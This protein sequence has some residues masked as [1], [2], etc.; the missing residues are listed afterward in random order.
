MNH[1]LMSMYNNLKA[2]QRLS[3]KNDSEIDME[4]VQNTELKKAMDEAENNQFDNTFNSIEEF[5]KA[6]QC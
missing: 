3:V 1:C 5:I 4:M 6:M 2:R